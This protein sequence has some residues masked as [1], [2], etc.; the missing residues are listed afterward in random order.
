MARRS[1]RVPPRHGDTSDKQCWYRQQTD[2]SGAKNTSNKLATQ[3][4]EDILG[5]KISNCYP[6]L[7]QTT[8]IKLLVASLDARSKDPTVWSVTNLAQEWHGRSTQR[9]HPINCRVTPCETQRRQAVAAHETKRASL[10]WAFCGDWGVTPVGVA[11]TLHASHRFK[12]SEPHSCHRRKT[13]FKTGF[14]WIPEIVQGSCWKSTCSK[15]ISM[16]YDHLCT[17]NM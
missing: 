6:L 14:C 12:T 8:S 5:Y 17:I 11:G 16:V 13:I 3:I 2:I 9:W 1:P 15:F 7:D 4:A 10:A